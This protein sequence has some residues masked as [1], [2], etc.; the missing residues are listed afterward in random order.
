MATTTV[1]LQKMKNVA[2]ELDKIHANITNQIKKLG[3]SVGSLEKL[4]KGDAAQAYQ[5]AYRQNA[6]NFSQLAAAIKNCST[7]LTTITTT[8]GKADTAAAEAIK[9]KMGGRK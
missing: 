5:S 4:W 9:S 1:D 2:S 6:S 7:S 8:Y 3:E